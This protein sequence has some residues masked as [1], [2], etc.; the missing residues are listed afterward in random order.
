MSSCLATTFTSSETPPSGLGVAS[1]CGFAAS[2]ASAASAARRAANTKVRS[3]E[4]HRVSARNPFDIEFLA[5]QARRRSARRRISWLKR[6][7]DARRG[8]GTEMQE[9]GNGNEV[10]LDPDNRRRCLAG[11]QGRGEVDGGRAMMAE[12]E[13]D[14]TI[15]VV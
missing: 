4:T 13:A 15:F 8:P 6:F 5:F 12:R 10:S 3:M 9:A 11:R 2:C 14:L 1:A 7:S